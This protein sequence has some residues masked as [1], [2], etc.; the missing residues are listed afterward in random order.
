[1]KAY[2]FL[3]GTV[4]SLLIT[5]NLCAADTN[6]VTNPFRPLEDFVDRYQIMLRQTTGDKNAIEKP[7]AFQFVNA[8]DGGKD[9]YAIDVGLTGSVIPNTS[10][11]A[12]N[13]YAGPTVEYHKQTLISKKQES[14]QAGATVI[15]ICGDVAEG[16]WVSI[17][18]LS[19]KYK[20]DKAN[21]GTAFLGM[22]DYTPL[23]PKF[24][25]GQIRGPE[26]CH[27]VWQPTVGAQ[28]ENGNNIMKSGHGGTDFRAKC[29]GQ[30][31][32]YPFGAAFKN[33][34]EIVAN[35]TYW[36]TVAEN[37][38]FNEVRDNRTLFKAGMTYYLDPKRHFGIGLDYLKG[39]DVE[40]GLPKQENLI[41]SLKVKF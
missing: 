41:A 7:A 19:L 1:M 39:E 36:R 34:L 13:W 30:V 10:Q 6:E 5:A 31:G 23:Y 24:L 15:D 25:L 35:F 14:F 18:Q 32:V 21:V 26:W 3:A 22:L 16:D 4:S 37:G 29:A 17:S 20:H 9:S 33:H 27:F 2:S 12:A 11:L 38:R 8:R 40:Q 28:V